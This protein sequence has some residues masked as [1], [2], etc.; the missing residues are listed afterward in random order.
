MLTNYLYL[1]LVHIYYI[2]IA[3]KYYG[4]I[5]N[6]SKTHLTLLN[7]EFLSTFYYIEIFQESRI[8]YNNDSNSD[9]LESK[10]TR[11]RSFIL[12][13]PSVRTTTRSNFL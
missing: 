8:Y 6:F 5:Q 1:L 2:E 7:L 4:N 13:V 12:C 10:N 9:Y 11:D 3:M